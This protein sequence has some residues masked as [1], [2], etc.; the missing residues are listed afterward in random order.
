MSL[1]DHFVATHNLYY[2]ANCCGAFHTIQTRFKGRWRVKRFFNYR[3]V[4]SAKPR[5]LFAER[6]FTL[7]RIV[8]ADIQ[9]QFEKFRRNSTIV[10]ATMSRCMEKPRF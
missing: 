3:I 5:S 10:Y 1:S 7:D 6:Y 2:L 4:D 8:Q 9:N